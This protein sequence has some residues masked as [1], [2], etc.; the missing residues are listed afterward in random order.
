MNKV[1]FRRDNEGTQQLA[2]F[3]AQLIR[4]G[5]T[6]EINNAELYVEV[7]VLGGY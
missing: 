6:Y 3:L 2:I 5:V 1:T 7:R 4:E